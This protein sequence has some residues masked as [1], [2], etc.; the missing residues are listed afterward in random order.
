MPGGPGYPCEPGLPGYPGFPME[1]LGPGAP[2][3]PGGPLTVSQLSQLLG[4]IDCSSCGSWSVE[5]TGWEIREKDK[6]SHWPA[7]SMCSFVSSLNQGC[8]GKHHMVNLFDPVTSKVACKLKKVRHP[9]LNHT[10][11]NMTAYWGHPESQLKRIQNSPLLHDSRVISVSKNSIPVSYLCQSPK[12][13]CSAE[14]HTFTVFSA[15]V[16][17]PFYSNAQGSN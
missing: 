14:Y 2:G 9:A 8:V 16:L 5:R 11:T 7:Y 17:T 4:T 3:W 13:W 12:S 1:P 10:Q 15:Q 6:S